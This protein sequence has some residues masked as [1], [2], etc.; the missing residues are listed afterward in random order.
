MRNSEGSQPLAGWSIRLR[1]AG[2]RPVSQGLDDL[3]VGLLIPT[4]ILGEA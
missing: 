1:P 4:D 2:K 3:V